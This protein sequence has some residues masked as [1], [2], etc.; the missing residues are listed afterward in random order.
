MPRVLEEEVAVVLN[1]SLL[2][3]LVHEAASSLQSL[4]LQLSLLLLGIE[5]ATLTLLLGEHLK[6]VGSTITL[7]DGRT[8][9]TSL[10]SSHGTT[11]H[12]L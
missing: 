1:F 4:L 6:Q 9:L 10:D 11:Q 7:D 2:V 3:E 12:R 5:L 8:E